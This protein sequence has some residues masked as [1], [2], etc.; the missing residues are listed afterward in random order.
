[1]SRRFFSV[2]FGLLV[3]FAAR[4]LLPGHYSINLLLTACL[5]LTGAFSGELAAEWLFPADILRA[6]GLA[7]S[8]LGSLAVLLVYAVVAQ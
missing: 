7:L 5:S 4:F 2:L 6:G 1:M 3:G 8:A